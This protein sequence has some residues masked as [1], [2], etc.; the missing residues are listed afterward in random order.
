MGELIFD[1]YAKKIQRGNNDLFNKGYW[2]TSISIWK[3]YMIADP[4][5]TAHPNNQL[6]LDE[7]GT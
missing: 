4:S 1:N 3:T 6:K 5:L 2:K 7:T